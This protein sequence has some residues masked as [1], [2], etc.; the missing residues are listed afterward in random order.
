MYNNG[1][2]KAGK[3]GPGGPDGSDS[4]GLFAP[5]TRLFMCAPSSR[6]SEGD[7]DPPVLHNLLYS[8]L[9]I[10]ALLSMTSPQPIRDNQQNGATNQY[11]AGYN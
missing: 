3:S 2:R 9:Q 5:R 10:A 8:S 6:N 7:T 4:V 11:A 1:P